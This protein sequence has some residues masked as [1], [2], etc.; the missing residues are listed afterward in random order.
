[1]LSSMDIAKAV[2]NHHVP[3]VNRGKDESI[4]S[5]YTDSKGLQYFRALAASKDAN[6]GHVGVRAN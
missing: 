2:I 6:I 4:D 1:M 3:F 5:Y